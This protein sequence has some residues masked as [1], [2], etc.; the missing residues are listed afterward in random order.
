MKLEKAVAQLITL[1][2]DPIKNWRK[3]PRDFVPSE[4][5][6]HNRFAKTTEVT[7]EIIKNYQNLS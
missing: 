4:F 5:R 3:I 6:N 2:A 1:A 7:Q